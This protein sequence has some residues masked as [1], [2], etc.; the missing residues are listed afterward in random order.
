MSVVQ[1][2]TRI[3]EHVRNRAAKALEQ[4]GLDLPSAIK[5]F[6]TRTAEVGDLP[7]AIGQSSGQYMD[8]YDW[9]FAAEIAAIENELENPDNIVEFENTDTAIDFLKSRVL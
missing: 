6:I 3:D 8:E 5:I 7:F 4:Y 9:S 2:S 1:I